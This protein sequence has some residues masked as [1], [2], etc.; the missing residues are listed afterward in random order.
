MYS[1]ELKFRILLLI[2]VYC[3]TI[4]HGAL[5]LRAEENS[6]VTEGPEQKG[7]ATLSGILV[8]VEMD[9]LEDTDWKELALED[10]EGDL[11]IIIG[12]KAGDLLDKVDK[13]VTLT[14]VYK[15]SMNMQG[16]S[17]PVLEVRFIDQAEE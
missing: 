15:P 9:K 1:K 6:V 10:A 3:L 16:R 14:G 4:P 17:V 13:Y 8:V 7:W 5:Y 2:A 11:T 12:A